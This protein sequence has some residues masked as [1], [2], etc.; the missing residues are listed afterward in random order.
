MKDNNDI[1]LPKILILLV[2]TVLIV[3]LLPACTSEIKNEKELGVTT[4]KINVLW[5]NESYHSLGFA[6]NIISINPDKFV[7]NMDAKRQ[8]Q[9]LCSCYLNSFSS[10]LF[11][12]IHPTS[13][14]N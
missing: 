7:L 9:H 8:L 6:D 3:F 5:E 4:N 10:H 11:L 12:Q 14:H 13:L 2:I 1:T